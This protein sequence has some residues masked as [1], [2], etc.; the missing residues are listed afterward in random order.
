MNNQAH[1]TLPLVVG[2]DISL[3]TIEVAHT[4]SDR[5][6]SHAYTPRGLA[7]IIRQLRGLKP[8][9]IVMEATGGLERLAARRLQAA[10][11]N[12]CVVN[13]RQV[14]D[15]ARAFNELAKT[16]AIDARIITRFGEVV[17]PRPS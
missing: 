3:H 4:G 14:R 13:P 2:M 5:V 11:F 16:D 17:R 12:V 10:G 8:E 1:S 9:R 6:G 15:F 7:T